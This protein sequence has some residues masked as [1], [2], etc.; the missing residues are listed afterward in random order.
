MVNILIIENDIKYCK[1]VINILQENN[2]DIRFC[3]FTINSGEVENLVNEF[4]FDI[5]IINYEYIGKFISI[6]EQYKDIIITI[7]PNKKINVDNLDYPYIYKFDNN[8]EINSKFLNIIDCK[9]R[10]RY[11]RYDIE[12]ELKYLGY[13]PKYYGTQYLIDVIDILYKND[14]IDDD[15]LEKNIYP[16]IA[17]KYKKTI[18]TI[19]CNIINAT[20][21]M[22]Y[23][24]DEEKLIKYLGY[25]NYSKPG[26]KKIIERILTK[27]QEKRYSE[28]NRLELLKR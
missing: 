19:K 5:I 26:P 13:N 15:K 16:I 12:N 18:N 27:I 24:C 14:N 21:M 3:I 23:E 1:K 2:K 22:V 7:I 9:E 8:K 20:D 17:K 28:I 10:K 4:D 6:L 25:F 11:L